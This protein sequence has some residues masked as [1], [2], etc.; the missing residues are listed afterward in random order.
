MWHSFRL[1]VHH[2]P[3]STPSPALPVIYTIGH[4]THPLE[5]FTELLR[6]HGVGRLSDVRSFPGSR[7]YP[8]FNAEALSRTLPAAGIEYVPLK[9]LGGRRRP[10]P[11]SPNTG[12]RNESFRGYADY[13]RTPPF[14]AGLDRLLRLAAEI[15]TAIMCSEAVPWRCHRNLIADALVLLRQ[16][17]VRHILGTEEPRPHTPTAIAVSRGGMIAYPPAADPQQQDFLRS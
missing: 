7:R 8:H 16:V 12:L 3:M 5:E 6:A 9:E 4:S 10:V 11:D 1:E 17:P 13:M 2:Q 14:A 15:P